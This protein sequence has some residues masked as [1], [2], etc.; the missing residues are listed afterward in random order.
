MILRH[1]R[2]LL[3]LSVNG[4]GMVGIILS[5]SDGDLPVI[6]QIMLP[7]ASL[8]EWEPFKDNNG[9]IIML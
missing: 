8:T 2:G 3:C 4:N 6:G 9:I 1:I 5:C 7:P